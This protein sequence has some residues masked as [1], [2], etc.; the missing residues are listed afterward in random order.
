MV[1]ITGFSMAARASRAYLNAMPAFA[2]PLV[3]A[4]TSA[5]ALVLLFGPSAQAA[6]TSAW[7]IGSHSA[8]RLI[9]GR[10]VQADGAL[11]A[12]IELKLAPG[13]KTYWRYPGDSGVPPRFDFSGSRN[14]KDV[15]VSFPAP[16]RFADGGGMSIGYTSAVVLPL[17]VIPIDPQTPATLR[18]KLDYA[19]C[20]KL[21]VPADAELELTLD[22]PDPSHEALLRASE[23]RLPRRVAI[24][25][26]GS[27][28]ITAVRREQGPKP[29]VIVEVKSSDQG[30]VDLFAEGP[31]ADW[32]LPLPRLIALAPAGT[33]RFAF[34]LDGLPPG[35]EPDGATL[36]LTAVS[37]SDAIEVPYHLD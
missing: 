14:V 8:V 19:I 11:R 5:A 23:A 16:V 15:Q 17:R 2:F 6:D 18:V 9:A 37:G 29:R 32:S 1:T 22:T 27:L 28:V 24:A 35:I 36:L 7:N 12:G 10:A 4:C 13:W 3:A 20:E 31:G 33:R 34:D 25:A 30:D 26:A 21:C